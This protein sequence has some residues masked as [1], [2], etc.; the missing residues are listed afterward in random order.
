MGESVSPL[1]LKKDDPKQQQESFDKQDVPEPVF[2]DVLKESYAVLQDSGFPFLLIG[3]I[4][5][6]ILGRPRY[7]QDIDY[8]VRPHDAH[9]VLEAFE[10]AGYAA[11]ET[12][13]DWLFKAVKNGVIIDL[14]FKSTGGIYLDDEMNQRSI[15]REFAGMKVRIAPPED[16]IVMKAVAHDE[17]TPRYWHD[18]LAIIARS[19]D[20][21]DWDYLLKRA[22]VGARRMLALLIYAQS[23][24]LVV[25]P[26]AV[27]QLYE[28]VQAKNGGKREGA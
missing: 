25:P 27:H 21:L 17:A 4:A 7:T 23:N 9:A 15:E 14:L 20:E 6:A 1:P 5:S 12:Y 13:P 2:L 8:L 19:G 3:G 11:Q 22:R 28:V 10:Q 18:A 26:D 24:D 16:I